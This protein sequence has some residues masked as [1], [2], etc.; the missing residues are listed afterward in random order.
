MLSVISC[1]TVVKCIKQHHAQNLHASTHFVNTGQQQADAQ[2]L[3]IK[4]ACQHPATEKQREGERDKETESLVTLLLLSCFRLVLCCYPCQAQ[5][6][7]LEPKSAFDGQHARGLQDLPLGKHPNAAC[8]SR[9]S[10][11]SYGFCHVLSLGFLYA[12]C[13]SSFLKA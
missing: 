4:G 13:V 6:G 1:P 12:F 7:S 2:R 3:P 8:I 10:F 11:R 9:A 5:H